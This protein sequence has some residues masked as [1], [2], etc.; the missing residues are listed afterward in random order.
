MARKGLDSEIIIAA[1]AR[2]VEE[3]G[4]DHFSLNE[5]ATELGVKTAS[6]YNHIEGIREVNSRISLLAVSQLNHILEAAI[7]QK[8]KD[9]ALMCLAL[10]YRNYAQKNPELY[11]AVIKLR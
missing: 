11:K 2:L 1:A 8:E 3:K 10:A 7:A 5:L 9:D 6:L 4:Y